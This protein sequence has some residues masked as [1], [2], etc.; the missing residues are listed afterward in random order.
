MTHRKAKSNLFRANREDG[1]LKHIFQF[2]KN[3]ETI[4]KVSII[5]SLSISNS[6]PLPLNNPHF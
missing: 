1:I 2:K 5:L 4:K 3:T 6:T